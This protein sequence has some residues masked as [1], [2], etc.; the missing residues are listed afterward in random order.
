LADSVRLDVA[1]GGSLFEGT[2]D[3]DGFCESEDLL[4]A[5][6]KIGLELTHEANKKK[7]SLEK[8]GLCFFELGHFVDVFPKTVV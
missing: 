8:C 1:T 2:T 7:G 5:A 4:E 3:P 6:I